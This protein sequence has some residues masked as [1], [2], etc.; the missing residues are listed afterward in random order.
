M[1]PAQS[2]AARALEALRTQFAQVHRAMRQMIDRLAHPSR[3]RAARSRLAA[4]GAWEQALVLCN[5]NIC[6]SPYAAAILRQAFAA[7]GLA[8][9]VNQ[10]GFLW[11]GRRSPSIAR[12]VARVRGVK[13]GGHRSRRVTPADT[14]G[15]TLVVVMES[16]QARRVIRELG[17]PPSRILLLGDLDPHPIPGR[18]I[19]D[20]WGA[21]PEVFE[22]VYGRISRCTLALAGCLA[23]CT[24][25]RAN[26]IPVRAA[27]D[28]ETNSGRFGAPGDKALQIR[29]AQG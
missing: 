21:G 27:G 11:P 17:V 9:P 24:E 15:R 22:E 19:T 23:G 6:R 20:P 8:I 5:G 3:R 29:L 1:N 4:N 14:H 18:G 7:Q 2:F 28:D 26:S 10:G 12:S 13:L 16:S 25:R